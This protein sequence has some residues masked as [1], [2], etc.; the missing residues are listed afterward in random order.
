MSVIDYAPTGL[1]TTARTAAICLHVPV[2]RQ[3]KLGQVHRQRPSSFLTVWPTVPDGTNHW[4]TP[5]F[6]GVP[7]TDVLV[8]V[9]PPLFSTCVYVPL[10][11]YYMD[12]NIDH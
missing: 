3:R 5:R 12:R 1:D 4:F 11:L 2:L 8:I 7:T 6:T 9:Y 10:G